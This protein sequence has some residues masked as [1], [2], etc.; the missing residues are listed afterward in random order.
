MSEG[1][2]GAISDEATKRVYRD[3][4]VDTERRAMVQTIREM[5]RQDG[6]VKEIHRRLA[7]D[8]IRGGLF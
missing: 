2:D 5:D 6:R 1:S 8:C 4:W 3:M 7:R